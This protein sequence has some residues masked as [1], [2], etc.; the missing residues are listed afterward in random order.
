MWRIAF[1]FEIFLT[2][3]NAQPHG[4]LCTRE[5]HIQQANVFLQTLFFGALQVIGVFFEVGGKRQKHQGVLQAFSLVK[6]DDLHQFCISLEAHLR[7]FALRLW[8]GQLIGEVTQ[9]SCFALQGQAGRLQQ[10]TQMQQVGQAPF[11]SVALF[12]HAT[13]NVLLVQHF[14]EHGQETLAL[15]CAV[16]CIEA[17]HPDVPTFFRLKD[18]LN[19]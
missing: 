9:Q 7:S 12:L 6:G 5:G 16:P 14:V 15:P 13:A 1:F 19:F 8:V 17:L 2:L 3:G 11:G 18:L 4:L 10:L